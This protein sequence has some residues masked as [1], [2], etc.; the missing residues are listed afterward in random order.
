MIKEIGRLPNWTEPS[1][2]DLRILLV[3]VKRSRSSLRIGTIGGAWN[4]SDKL[5]HAH[6]AKAK[7]RKKK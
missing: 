7:I 6:T 1:K 4:Q 5:V 3:V 2:L